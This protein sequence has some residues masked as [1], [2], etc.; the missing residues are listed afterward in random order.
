MTVEKS[1]VRRIR[2]LA[3]AIVM[4]LATAGPSRSDDLAKSGAGEPW[5][6]SSN[7]WQQGQ[8]LLPEPVL[9]RVK[10]G[11]YWYNVH[12]VDPVKFRQNYSEHFWKASAANHGKFDVDP[13]TC[14]LKDVATGKIADF[15]FGHPFPNVGADDPQAA[16]KM[17]WN[18]TAASQTLTGGGASLTLNGI[19]R[20]GE[21]RRIKTW[22]RVNFYLG[23]AQGR[24]K[25][26]DNL[27]F[28]G[29]TGVV[30][31]RD[32][33]GVAGL[34]KQRNDWSSQDQSWF[35]VPSTRRVRRVDASNRSDPVAGLDIY[36]DDF[37]CYA[38]KVEFYKWKLIG[39]GNVLAPVLSAEPLPQTRVSP[40][41]WEVTIPYFKAAYE[42]PG[43]EGAP[44]LIV[45]NLKMIPRP[46]WIIEGQS[47]DPYYNFGKV[48]MYMDKE[49]YRIYWKLVHNRA[50]EY[51]YNAMC[52]YH[53][54]RSPDGTFA[55]VTPNMIIGVNDK[56][57]RAAIAGRYD[58]QFIETDFDE[59]FFTLSR[60][61][62]L[63]E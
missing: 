19:D 1:R 2:N 53:W 13:E 46:V 57:D 31:P 24:T 12:P 16:C 56:A 22:G 28:A 35:Y 9:S 47:E 38:G 6:L 55:A 32:V 29:M 20:G 26:P 51:F 36:L 18:F 3:L 37:N 44:W 62:R 49:M 17:A 21:Y 63:S 52:A 61:S 27:R 54:S 10:S 15:Y 14:G 30:E 41:R 23:R 5:I 48:I 60:L 25:N 11:D 34:I 39:E 59:K 50:G 42:T 40:T 58:S 45:E 8:G 33:K 7:N 43:A 4:I